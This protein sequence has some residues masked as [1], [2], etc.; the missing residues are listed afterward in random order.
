MYNKGIVGHCQFSVTSCLASTHAFS[1][2]VSQR[3]LSYRYDGRTPVT[4]CSSLAQRTRDTSKRCPTCRPIAVSHGPRIDTADPLPS[5]MS[6]RSG[7]LR[8]V[9]MF[10]RGKLQTWAW[11]LPLRP[12]TVCMLPSP[13]LI[14]RYFHVPS[15]QVKT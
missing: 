4:A 1:I 9:Q 14:R 5:Y 10:S 6:T 12:K 13:G 7:F 11:Q 3:K 8:V 2:L 15:Q